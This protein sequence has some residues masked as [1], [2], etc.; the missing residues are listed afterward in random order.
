M[1]IRLSIK[2]IKMLCFTKFVFTTISLIVFWIILLRGVWVITCRY[3]LISI[4]AS[5]FHSVYYII[6][7]TYITFY[8]KIN[9]Y[10]LKMFGSVLII[11]IW[12]PLLNR[13]HFR[14]LKK[15]QYRSTLNLSKYLNFLQ[16]NIIWLKQ[17]FLSPL[18]LY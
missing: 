11:E 5:L 2:Y 6:Q 9:T 12:M 10:Q 8:K 17:I 16:K 13:N 1:I 14:V 7:I 15:G 18:T 4:D 3:T